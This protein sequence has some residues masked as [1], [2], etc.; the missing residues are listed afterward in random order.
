MK[1]QNSEIPSLRYRGGDLHHLWSKREGGNYYCRFS[2]LAEGSRFKAHRR[3]CISLRTS[4][5]KIAIAR[6]DQILADAVEVAGKAGAVDGASRKANVDGSKS[7]SQLFQK[8]FLVGQ[9]MGV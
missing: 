9:P 6:R 2:L 4:D 1:T 7:P 5:L 3:T 8:Y